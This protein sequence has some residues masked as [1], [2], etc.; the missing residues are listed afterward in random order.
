MLSKLQSKLKPRQLLRSTA[1]LTA[2]S[3]QR[4]TVIKTVFRPISGQTQGD[5]VLLVCSYF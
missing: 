2:K 4:I 1:I 3:T 5:Y